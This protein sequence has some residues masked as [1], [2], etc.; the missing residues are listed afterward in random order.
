ML[1][2]MGSQRVGQELMAEQQNTSSGK[3]NLIVSEG[4]ITV[5]LKIFNSYE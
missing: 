1:Q 5:T 3:L 4:F 2:S